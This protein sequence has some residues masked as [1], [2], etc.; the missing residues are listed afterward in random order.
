MNDGSELTVEFT[1]RPADIYSP[2]RWDRDNLV[3]WVIACLLGYIFYDMYT[4]SAE[5]LRSF[6]SGNSILAIVVLL[7]LLILLALL[8]FPFLRVLAIYRG[9]PSF[10]S[11]KRITFRPDM[12]L[13]ESAEA[14]SECKW[15]LYSRVFETRRTFVFVQGKAGGIYVPKRCFASPEDLSLLRKLI[16]EN[17]KG[18]AVL[19]VD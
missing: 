14:K 17:F 13:L 4:R 9:T 3:R 10:S 1:L 19:R 8:L 12:I 2:F 18:Q 5:T 6:D 11:P 15:A 7:F 16:R